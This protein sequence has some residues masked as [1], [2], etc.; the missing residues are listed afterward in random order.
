MNCRCLHSV[1]ILG[2]STRYGY[3]SIYWSFHGVAIQ[4]ATDRSNGLIARTGTDPVEGG[5]KALA[6]ISCTEGMTKHI[7]LY[8]AYIHLYNSGYSDFIFLKGNIVYIISNTREMKWAC[9]GH[10]NR[11]KDKR[12]TSRVTTWRPYDNEMRTTRETSQ[13]RRPAETLEGYVTASHLYY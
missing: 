2:E 11:L 8:N 4:E 9:T 12:W 6:A 3:F 10:I 5:E 1:I 13:I 7:G